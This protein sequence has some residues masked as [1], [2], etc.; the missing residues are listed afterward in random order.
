MAPALVSFSRNTQ[1]VRVGNPVRQAQSQEPHERQAVVDEELRALVREIVRRLN[2]QDLDHQHRVERRPAALQAIRVGQ[3]P[4]QLGP[5]NLEVHRRRKSQQLIVEVAQPLQ[6]L[7]DIEKSSLTAHR[8]VSRSTS[9][10]ESE[11][12]GRREVLRSVHLAG[13]QR[14]VDDPTF[15]EPPTLALRRIAGVTGV[16]PA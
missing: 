10:R 15:F 11:N 14:V 13:P 1:I 3:R 5:E 2:H 8:F 4:R 6:P 16:G 12:A 9:W 7:I